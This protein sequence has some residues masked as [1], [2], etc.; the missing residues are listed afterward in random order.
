MYAPGKPLSAGIL[1]KLSVT[2]KGLLTKLYAFSALSIDIAL[3]F[4]DWISSIST[5]FLYY[6]NTSWLTRKLRLTDFS[7]IS[8]YKVNFH[9]LSISKQK[10]SAFAKCLCL[11]PPTGHELVARL[12]RPSATAADSACTSRNVLPGASGSFRHRLV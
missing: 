12:Y 4:V 7:G 6:F 2:T 10:H 1:Q 9:V 5:C 3:G 11:A 8:S